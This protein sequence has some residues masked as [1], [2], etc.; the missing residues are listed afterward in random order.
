M[1][2]LKTLELIGFFNERKEQAL[3][4]ITSNTLL[5]FQKET[6]IKEYIEFQK[7]SKKLEIKNFT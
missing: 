7:V 5:D 2:I 1:R 6:Y 3:L 4:E